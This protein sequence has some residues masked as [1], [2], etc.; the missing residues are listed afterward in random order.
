MHYYLNIQEQIT[1]IMKKFTSN[2]LK[3]QPNDSYLT[4]IRDGSIY[5]EFSNAEEVKAQKA[6]SLLINT[7]GISIAKNSKLTCWPIFFVINELPIEHR[8][9]IDNIILAGKYKYFN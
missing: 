7:D 4:D 2:D 1:N 9:S 5:K 8:F 3:H 6:F